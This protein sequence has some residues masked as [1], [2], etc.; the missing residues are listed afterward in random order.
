MSHHEDDVAIQLNGKETRFPPETT[1][2]AFL[3]TRA[4]QGKLVV[5]E[6]NG[7]IVP[8]PEFGSRRFAAGDVVEVVHFVGGG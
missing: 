2:E 6:I 1:I 4:L 5:V 8:R 3:E 7:A